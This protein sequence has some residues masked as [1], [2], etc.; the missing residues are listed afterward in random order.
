MPTVKQIVAYFNNPILTPLEQFVESAAIDDSAAVEVSSKAF[1]WGKVTAYSEP[2]TYGISKDGIVFQGTGFVYG[3]DGLPTAGVITSISI[4][5][6]STIRNNTDIDP[7]FSLDFT[8]LS[9]D[10]SEMRDELLAA[11]TGDVTA[12]ADYFLGLQWA[13]EGADYFNGDRYE[14]G[15]LAD[16]IDGKDGKNWL[17]GL[18]GDDVLRGGDGDDNLFGG[19]GD[20]TLVG[21]GGT[22]YLNGGAG[23]DVL[24]G[25]SGENWADYSGAPEFGVVASLADPSRNTGD[26][27][28]DVYLNVQNLLGSDYNDLLIGDN[29]ANALNGGKGDDTF[30]GGGGADSFNGGDRSWILDPSQDGT[31]LVDYSSSVSGLI[32]SLA[33]PQNNTGNAKGDTYR[34]IENLT[35][36]NF[37]DS[38]YGTNVA[39]VISGLNGNDLIKGYGG[40]DTLSGGGG[41][42]TLDGGEGNDTLSGG[43]GNDTLDGGAGLDTMAGGTGDDLYIVNNIG[44]KAIETASAGTDTVQSSVTYGLAGTHVENLF[45]TGSAALDAVGNSLDNIIRGNSGR[46]N[47]NGSGGNDRIEGG[48]GADKLTGGTGVD[49]FVFTK[50][51]DSTVAASGRDTI[52][53]FAR[54]QGEKVD[55]SA[56]DANTALAG[57]QAFKF[58]GSAAYSN[59]AGELRYGISGDQTIISGDVNGDGVTDFKIALDLRLAM[60]ASDF[61]L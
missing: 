7:D 1:V 51:S 2:G 15:N 50:L 26:A 43:A 20:D 29:N 60:V 12:L 16:I 61:I 55:L 11:L 44:D 10:L 21:K 22:N 37:N 28:G 54:A 9:I 39:N 59:K 58:I 17:Y 45:L 4:S 49:T 47:L 46:N 13:Y 31:D 38:L 35:G 25:G 6:H 52:L 14:G 53:D 8:G 3:D 36:S 32:V 48:G 19:D 57:N 5:R 33:N 41:N 30:V 56:I 27:R 42:D 24:I 18:G 40:D 23:A 34:S